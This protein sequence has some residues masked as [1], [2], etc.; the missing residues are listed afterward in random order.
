MKNYNLS[1]P[2]VAAIAAC[3]L[4]AQLAAVRSHAAE[5]AS[6]PAPAVAAASIP[7]PHKP[8][9]HP[10]P[11]R[12]TVDAIDAADHTLQ[13]GGKK[14]DRT[15]HVTS[16]SILERDGKPLKFEEIARGDYAHGLVSRPDG[17][18]EVVVKAV[19]GAKPDK[20]SR[21]RDAGTGR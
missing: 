13:L 19:F 6:G 7:A 11:F 17:S 8:S 1:Q 3:L 4:A 5:A 16:E 20:K 21:R 2:I 15:V 9:T 18:R 12:G 10:Y 14:S